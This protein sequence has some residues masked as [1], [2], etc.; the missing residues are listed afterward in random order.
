VPSGTRLTDAKGGLYKLQINTM[1]GW[2]A[3]WNLTALVQ[4]SA[5]G[6]NRGSWG[7]NVYMQTFDAAANTPA[8]KAAWSWNVSIPVGLPGSVM[9]AKLGDKVLGG[10]ASVN[11]VES[12]ALSL[13]PGME[14]TEIF[15][16]SWAAP[17]DWTS[18]NVTVSLA[19]E[20]LEEGV[21]AV[22]VK[23][24]R[25]YYGFSAE[26]GEF[27]WE[28]QPQDY[29][30]F[31]VATETSIVYGKMYSAGVSGVVYCYDLETG[32]RVWTYEANDPYQEILWANNWWAQILFITDGKV[33]LGH[34]EHS[35]LNPL[36]RGAPFYC[37][38]ATTGEEI[39]RIDGA[40]RQTHWGGTAI[41][42][43]SIIATQDTYDQRVYAIG[44]GPSA[45]S[46]SINTNVVPI[47]E[48]GSC[49]C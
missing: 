30:D 46:I 27:L 29:L 10:T 48:W 18:G 1:N 37:L 8:A 42:G 21:F 45:T 2:M 13:Q 44:K 32:E 5:F 9:A 14:G 34:S 6:S 47:A 49:S 38:N 22:W 26:T 16:E 12:W 23:E 20:S 17:A 7:N 19:G 33:Y 28:T 31:H 24:S 39:F 40:F 15:R 43:D 25:Q 41:I 11:G 35:P 36:P 3:L 4:N